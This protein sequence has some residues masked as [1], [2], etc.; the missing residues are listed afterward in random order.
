MNKILLI[1]GFAFIYNVQ[2]A[3][4]T[5][6]NTFTAGTPAVAAEVNS[7]FTAVESA[8]DDNNTNIT[9]NATGI[10][11][12][13]T[14]IGT[15]QNTVTGTCPTGQS[16]RVI[17][18]DGTVTCEVDTDT[19][20]N[21][22]YSTGSGLT[23]SGTTFSADTSAIQSRVTDVC[24]PGQAIGAI[25]ADGTVNCETGGSGSSL[26]ADLLDGNDSSAFA[27]ALHTHAGSLYS[28][29]AIVAQNGGDYTS[30][31]TAMANLAS[32]CGAPSVTNPCLLHIMPGVYDLGNNALTMQPYVDI[33][34]SGENTTI[35]SSTHSAT[36]SSNSAT[37]VGADNAEIRFLTVENR[38]GSS[39]TIAIHNTSTS[40]KI[41]NVT[42]TASGGTIANIGVRNISSSSIMKSMTA[43]ASG[44]SSS[45]GVINAAF[46]S[47]TMTNVSATASGGTNQ[48]YGVTN[49]NSSTIMTN[50][51]ATVSGVA[52]NLGVYN[53][54][55]SP[56]MTNVTATASG[57]ISNY[58]VYNSSSSPRIKNSSLSGTTSS[59]YNFGTNT[60]MVGVTMLEGSVVG[61][62]F[63]C[64]GA[65]REGF[66]ALGSSCL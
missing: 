11:A 15:K 1:L 31:L 10:G 17:N 50:V 40:P 58:G 29:V 46:S 44:G 25:N 7:N 45:H 2:A 48:N 62:G 20:T 52:A 5:I 26:D 53:T 56:T 34:G 30:P 49:D 39:Y 22:T 24:P 18:S 23:L 33:E 38:G 61:T 8:V 36:S 43:T 12:N 65:Y 19:D 9:T 63:T 4:L 55:S 42:V 60:V 51:T 13:T 16:I 41:T 59:I 37:L 3:D 66:V 35:I 32:W 28:K 47:T 27:N 6:P 57:G 21:T 64:V 54:S 14:S